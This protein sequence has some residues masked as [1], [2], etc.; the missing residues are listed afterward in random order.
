MSLAL[1]FGVIGYVARKT[2]YHVAAILIGVILGPLMETYFLRAM[3]MSEGDIM[4]IFSS[5]IGNIL[6]VF[7]ILSMALPYFIDYRRKKF[8]ARIA[9][10]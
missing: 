8:T 9:S 5:T 1:V 2:G 7:L 10:D 6:W 4:V 3:K